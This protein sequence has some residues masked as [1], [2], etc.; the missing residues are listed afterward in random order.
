MQAALHV[1]AV[2]ASLTIG[3]DDP[4]VP[5]ASTAAVVAALLHRGRSG[6]A[7]VNGR[8]PELDEPRPRA[9]AAPIGR[10]TLRR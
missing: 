8:A 5:T 2:Y 3:L 1:D 10:L 4:A 9:E 7:V 6:H